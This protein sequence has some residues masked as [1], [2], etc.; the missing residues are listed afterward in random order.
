MTSPPFEICSYART[1]SIPNTSLLSIALARP[2]LG[3]PPPK[4]FMVSTPSCRASSDWAWRLRPLMGPSVLAL[5]CGVDQR[6]IGDGPRY[7]TDIG[8]RVGPPGARVARVH[9]LD[10]ADDDDVVGRI[11][12]EPGAVHAAPVVAACADRAAVEIGVCWIE[13]DADSHAIADAR[14]R[15]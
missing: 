4:S 8:H 15:L 7:R 10:H 14:E 12:P 2:L 5:A 6:R 13:H 1:P 9:L 3:E 11:D